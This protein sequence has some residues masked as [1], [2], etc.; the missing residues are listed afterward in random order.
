MAATL[1]L[2]SLHEAARNTIPPTKCQAID[3]NSTV[4]AWVSV[5]SDGRVSVFGQDK[6][7]GLRVTSVE[8]ITSH[9]QSHGW[10]HPSLVPT[11]LEPP[12]P[13]VKFSASI[14]CTNTQPYLQV[15]FGQGMQLTGG[16]AFG[17][18]YVSE[19][20]DS[21]LKEHGW[22]TCQDL[23]IPEYAIQACCSTR[24]SISSALPSLTLSGQD[25]IAVNYKDTPGYLE[26]ILTPVIAPSKTM[27]WKM[28]MVFIP[29]GMSE[30]DGVI[31]STAKGPASKTAVLST[32]SHNIPK[33]MYGA[34]PLTYYAT[35]NATD[36]FILIAE[37]VPVYTDLPQ[38]RAASEDP[39]KIQAFLKKLEPHIQPPPPPPSST[40]QPSRKCSWTNWKIIAL[41]SVAFAFLIVSIV[42]TIVLASKTKSK[43]Q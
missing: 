16:W 6:S 36:A 11:S 17:D 39:V 33:V 10:F 3:P 34:F 15:V 37:W 1:A 2:V 12:V 30:A 42:L 8:D 43:K 25:L 28:D 32:P 18:K 35:W 41:G 24:P 21:F 4:Y 7:G 19:P 9:L 27:A 13:S 22:S 14:S 23:Q 31:L 5:G 38:T 20:F 29:Q 26:A 40:N